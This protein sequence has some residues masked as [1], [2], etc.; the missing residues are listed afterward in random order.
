MAAQING[1]EIEEELDLG[2]ILQHVLYIVSE[3]R[4]VFSFFK[5]ATEKGEEYALHDE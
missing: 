2:V 3:K 1:G 5:M 4:T